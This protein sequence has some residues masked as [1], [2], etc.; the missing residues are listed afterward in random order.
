MNQVAINDYPPFNKV[1]ATLLFGYV[2]AFFLQ[3]GIRVNMLG[4]IRVEFLLAA[5]LLGIAMFQRPPVQYP[6]EKLTGFLMFFLFCCTIQVPFSADFDLSYDIYVNR[7]LKFAAMAFIIARLVNSPAM[8]C[9]YLAAFF[10]SCLKMGQEG[11]LGQLTGSLVWENQGVMRLHGATPMYAHPNSF[12]GMALGTLPFIYYLFPL[13]KSKL[14]KLLLLAQLAFSIN[15]IIFCGSR[16]AYVAFIGMMVFIFF[17]SNHKKLFMLGGILLFFAALYYMPDQYIERF[18]S[19]FTGKEK[20]GASTDTRIQILRDAVQIFF[21][22]PLGVGVGAFPVVRAE[23]FGLIQDTHNLYLEIATNLGVQGLLA[24]FLLI[25]AIFS[26]YRK[27]R[28]SIVKQLEMLEKIENSEPDDNLDKHRRQLVFYRALCDTLVTYLVVRL[29]LG[30]FGMDMYEIYWWIVIG[31]A[32]AL[33]KLS[34]IA[35]KKTSY[36]M[37]NIQGALGVGGGLKS[38]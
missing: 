4:T 33:S 27:S 6:K 11:L 2:A 13:A 37:D 36:L 29:F 17:K 16:T 30:V 26:S 18:E 5:S 31:F 19:I 23:Y 12:S 28:S 9:V 14:L 21:W 3:L 1:V 7:I 34:F 10:V 15:I 22:Y 25:A 8:A 24:F 32:Y 20:E 38:S 35:E